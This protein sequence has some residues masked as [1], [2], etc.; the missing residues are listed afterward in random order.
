MKISRKMAIQIL[1]YLDKHK[2]FY[3]PFQVMYDKCGDDFVEIGPGEWK[4]IELNGEYKIFELRENLQDLDEKTTQLMARGF[5]E[6]I[7]GVARIFI[8]YTTEGYTFQ[9]NSENDIPDVENC[10]ILG[11]GKGN[12]VE[13][14]FDNFKEESTWLEDLEFDEVIGAELKDEEA[15][16]FNLKDKCEK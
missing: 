9:P 4:A 8:F 6:E 10:Q 3:F 15:Y 14:A 16:H 11:W 2:D 13:E 12:T 7:Q 5:I 1:K